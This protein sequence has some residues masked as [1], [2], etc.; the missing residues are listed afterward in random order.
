MGQ[1][2]DRPALRPAVSARTI[3]WGILGTGRAAGEFARGLRYVRGADLVAV[4]SRSAEKAN[5]FARM[6]GARRACASY[7]Q[8][9]ADPAV[10]VVYVA[11]PLALHM[12]HCLLALEAGK[13][14]LCEKP[15]TASAEEALR[16][17]VFA[18]E[19]RLFCM[20]AMWMHFLPA[21]QKAMELI[22]AGAIG[23]P[24]ML[25]A[26][27]GIPVKFDPENRVFNLALGGGA[28]M[29]LG[30][31]PLALA[32]RLFG[33]PEKVDAM[34]NF[35]V[36]GVDEQSSAMI[37]YS[38]GEIA[39][40]AA[41]LTGYAANEAVVVGTEG[42]ITI[43]EPLCR[44]DQLTISRAPAPATEEASNARSWLKN[45]LRSNRLVRGLHGL[46][47][48]RA[49]TVHV[50]YVGNG[51]N[52][53]ASE[54]GKCLAAGAIESEVWSLDQTAGVM[55]TLDLVRKRWLA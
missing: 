47:A 17:I 28:M 8:L 33:E 22:R 4:G 9:V 6:S 18:R 3:G 36:T 54:V 55:R 19:R 42:R 24:R 15:F 2:T 7:E 10:D 31:Y 26:D 53:E 13:A 11:T 20:E 5:R 39:L 23:E 14:V 43:H 29:D 16:V 40:L 48:G 46:V 30:V 50:P 51:Y 34:S 21:M 27:F 35:A 1:V 32:W 37:R 49:S 25:T 38:G 41:T 45:C 44:P 52:Y 12:S